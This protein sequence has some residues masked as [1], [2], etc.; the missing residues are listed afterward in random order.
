MSRFLLSLLI[1]TIPVSAARGHLLLYEN[2]QVY[3]VDPVLIRLEFSIHAPE[4]PLAV[5]AGIDPTAVEASWLAGLDADTRRALRREAEIFL[6]ETFLV[7]LAEGDALEGAVVNFLPP[8]S[9][10]APPG[11][12]PAWI[13]LPNPGET[14]AFT[15]GFAPS[16]EKRLLLSIARPAAFPEVHDLAPGESI[17]VRLP[18]APPAPAAPSS[19][20][21]S[22]WLGGI[23]GGIIG[24]AI[25]RLKKKRS[26]LANSANVS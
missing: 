25:W 18:P 11:C 16:A 7:R 5:A 22:W 3:L 17:S 21:A 9:S 6:R 10:E 19:S 4:L 14:T 2:V 12:L 26:E 15:V 20:S 13:E 1:L 24:W 8:G 23:L